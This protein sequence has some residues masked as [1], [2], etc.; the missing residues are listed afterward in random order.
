MALYMGA[1]SFKL[2]DIFSFFGPFV[3]I[4][5]VLPGAGLGSGF[6]TG[7]RLPSPSLALTRYW[8]GHTQV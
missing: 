4:N 2:Q 5:G 1:L 6:T 7:A 3:N 8:S